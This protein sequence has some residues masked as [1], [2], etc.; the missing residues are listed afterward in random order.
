M[1]T[2]APE[3]FEK[4][5]AKISSQKESLG[6]R[7]KISPKLQDKLSA[8]FDNFRQGNKLSKVLI[9]K[10]QLKKFYYK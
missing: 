3:F 1:G 2:T 6:K 9:D 5:T 7:Y 8:L 10:I 4:I